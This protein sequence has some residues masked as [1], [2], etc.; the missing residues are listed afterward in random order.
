M[1]SNPSLF[2]QFV[3]VAESIA[4]TPELAFEEHHA[5]SVLTSWL[6]SHGFELQ[7]VDSVDTAFV[8]SIGEGE[9]SIALLLEYDALPNIGHG[10]G[11]HLIGAGCALAGILAAK[12]HAGAGKIVLVGCPAEESGAGKAHLLEAGVFDG[13]DAAMMFHPASTTVLARSAVAAITITVEFFGRASHTARAP[14]HGRNALSSAI[15]L[16]NAIDALRVRL[17]R[18]ATVSGII[19]EGG[20]AVNVV[21]EYVS[22]ELLVRDQSTSAVEK[23]LGEIE[24]IAQGAALAA[25]TRAKVTRE[26][27]IYTERRSNRTMLHALAPIMLENG[28]TINQVGRDESLGSSDIG[29][30]S[31]AIPTIH[32]TVNV[33]EQATPSHTPEFAH[34]TRKPLAYERSAAMARSIACL[35]VRIL[36]DPALRK[37]MR[38]EFDLGG[39]DRPGTD[40]SDL[41]RY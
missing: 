28:L 19:A 25:G 33:V 4:D 16:F 8:A 11:H 18:W 26:P 9:P 40:F 36:T 12:Q 13:L 32:P 14:E 1:T 27:Y 34:A 20:T 39:Y 29:N 21:P 17:G 30:V 15:F 41:R 31:L 10:C 37:D 3:R 2:E 7:D 38:D 35:A 5:K 23:L 24:M 22:V 6:A